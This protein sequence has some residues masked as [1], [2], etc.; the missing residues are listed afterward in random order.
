MNTGPWAS[1]RWW[2][3]TNG[4]FYWGQSARY[5]LFHLHQWAQNGKEMCDRFSLQ[6]FKML[7]I[8]TTSNPVQYSSFPCGRV[9]DFKTVIW[10]KHINTVCEAQ[11]RWRLVCPAEAGLPACCCSGGSWRTC[12]DHPSL[13]RWL[14][15]L[16]MSGQSYVSY[17]LPCNVLLLQGSKL[18]CWVRHWCYRNAFWW[19][20]SAICWKLQSTGC[21]A[22]AVFACISACNSHMSKGTVSQ[23]SVTLHL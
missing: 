7:D 1:T 5:K 8:Y 6:T 9:A 15:P 10:N 23:R 4:R 12:Q 20:H 19:W 18:L 22:T 11:S 21:T 16:W 2:F 14:R 17:F 13:Y 3:P